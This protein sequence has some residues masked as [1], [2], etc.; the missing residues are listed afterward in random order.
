MSLL[1]HGNQNCI[2]LEEAAPIIS[3]HEPEPIESTPVVV[4]EEPVGG[5]ITEE[6][7]EQEKNKKKRKS[8]WQILKDALEE[9]N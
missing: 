7:T 8:I 1:L 6:A 5:E 4:E 2:V 3:T 9:D